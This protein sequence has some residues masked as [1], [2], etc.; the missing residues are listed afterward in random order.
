MDCKVH[1]TLAFQE[2]I[3]TRRK[4]AKRIICKKALAEVSRILVIF[5]VLYGLREFPMIFLKGKVIPPFHDDQRNAVIA[6]ILYEFRHLPGWTVN[7][8]TDLLKDFL[9]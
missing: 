9:I 8:V 7:V 3:L 6:H 4:P 5:I 1:E 2:W